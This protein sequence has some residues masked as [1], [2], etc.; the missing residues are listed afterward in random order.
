MNYDKKKQ[1]FE[2][3]ASNTLMT[4]KHRSSRKP[5][6]PDLQLPSRHLSRDGTPLQNSP[7]FYLSLFSCSPTKAIDATSDKI[8]LTSGFEGKNGLTLRERSVKEKTV[9]PAAIAAD[10]R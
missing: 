1:H 6:Q 4:S 3:K 7:A 5:S 9:D 10:G 8:P 2:A